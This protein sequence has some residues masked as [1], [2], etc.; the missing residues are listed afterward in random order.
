VISSTWPILIGLIALAAGA[1][2][3]DAHNASADP[4]AADSSQAQVVAK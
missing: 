4:G 3:Y 2:L 1:F